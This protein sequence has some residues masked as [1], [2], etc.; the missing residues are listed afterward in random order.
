MKEQ[1][2]Y[3]INLMLVGFVAAIV[4]GGGNVNAEITMGEPTN[5]GPVINDATDMQECD[6]SHDGLELYFSTG[7][8]GGYGLKD[9]WV[10]KRET[11][12]SPWQEPV[13]LGPVVNSSAGE[14]EPS[15]S[16]D[17]LELY[18]GCWD[19]YILRVCTRPSKN[20]PWGSPVKIGPPVGSV[21]PAMEIG[22]NDAWTPEISADGLSLYFTS[23]R[24]GGYGKNDIWMAT[25]STTND[26][27]DEPMN[28]GPNVNS[29]ANEWSPSI[30]TDGLTL[31]FSRYSGGG[32]LWATTRRSTNDDWGPAVRLPLDPPTGWLH[33]PTLS[34]DGSTLYFE[35]YSAWGGYGAGDFWQVTF[36]PV[37]DFDADG[38]IDIADLVI[39]IE[40][41]GEEDPLCDIGP[42][43]LGD[44]VVD[45][46]DLKVFMSHW[47]QEA[48][49]PALIAHWKLDETEGDIAYNIISDNHGIISGNPT[50]QPDNGQVAGALQF[51]GID[52]YISTD[53]VLNPSDSPFSIF[54]WIKNGTAGQAILS[55][56]NGAYW[57]MADS[58]DG[59]LKTDLKEPASA[60]R[61]PQPPG[62]PLIC[63]TVVTDGDWHRVGFVRDGINRILYVDDVEVARD[64]AANLEAA[65][66]GLYIGAGSGLE[67][68]TFWSGLIDDVR[69]YNVALSEE[70]IAA[71]AE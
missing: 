64:T 56:E 53:F 39:L 26:D 3:R 11:V 18:L 60:G 25:R 54:A 40:H 38:I 58:V 14:L 46:A 36:T 34:P 44:G 61:D 43:P 20:A 47:G 62:P 7:R 27:W 33:G 23:T 55:Q 8:P 24:V 48:Y 51:D 32:S 70:E 67:S 15:I 28:L 69:I 45:E 22:S 5:L 1:G 9:I 21:E 12:N 17:G 6:F 42:L 68:G 59:V 66:G 52:D 16:G 29:G 41:W 37:I 71:L 50:W 57:L 49:D 4:I 35:A 10:A 2:N 19:D 30:S 13:N 31:V 65:S 63:S